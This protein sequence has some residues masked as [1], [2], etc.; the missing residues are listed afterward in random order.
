MEILTSENPI[1]VIDSRW[2]WNV[3]RSREMAGLLEETE[4]ASLG[5]G[6]GGLMVGGGW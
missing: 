2:N 3:G 5:F 4:M 6:D 1:P